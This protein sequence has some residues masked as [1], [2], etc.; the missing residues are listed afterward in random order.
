MLGEYSIILFVF[1][2]L[3]I[4][5]GSLAELIFPKIIQ[6][7]KSTGKVFY[8][9]ETAFVFFPT[10]LA[11]IIANLLMNFFIEKFTDYSYLLS[12]LHL[13]SWAVL[14]HAIIS[15]FYHTLNALDRRKNIVIINFIALIIYIVFLYI[16]LFMTID[17]LQSLILSK[18]LFGICLIILYV[19]FLYNRQIYNLVR[20]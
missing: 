1:A 6:K 5:P 7:V 11:V 12:Y 19:L 20:R 9:K 14:P 13:I 8:F 18:M 17:I 3:M 2:T 10:L 16:S 15:I 4:I